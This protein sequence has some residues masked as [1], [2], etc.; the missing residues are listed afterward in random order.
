MVLVYDSIYQAVIL[1]T[2]LFILSLSEDPEKLAS[3]NGDPLMGSML[4]DRRVAFRDTPK[5]HMAPG[6]SSVCTWIVA[7]P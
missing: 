5:P 4:E 3:F 7:S 2:L 6:S 1:G